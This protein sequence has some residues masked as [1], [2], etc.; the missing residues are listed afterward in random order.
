M[1]I[2]CRPQMAILD[3]YKKSQP[4]ISVGNLKA[5]VDHPPAKREKERGDSHSEPRRS[6]ENTQ[7]ALCKS[8]T[9]QY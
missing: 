1:I 7:P 2:L 9:H 5:G 8:R 4:A 3:F 6:K